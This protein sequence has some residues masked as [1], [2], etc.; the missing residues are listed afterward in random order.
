M[1]PIPAG[2]IRAGVKHCSLKSINILMLIYKYSDKTENN[3]YL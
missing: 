2:L 1:G 3:N